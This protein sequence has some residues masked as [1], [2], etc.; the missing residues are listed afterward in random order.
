MNTLHALIFQLGLCGP[1]KLLLICIYI[2]LPLGCILN[3]PLHNTHDSL[4]HGALTNVDKDHNPQDEVALTAKRKPSGR[5]IVAE[6]AVGGSLSESKVVSCGKD[7]NTPDVQNE[8]SNDSG[9]RHSEEDPFQPGEPL[10]ITILWKYKY[11]ATYI[12]MITPPR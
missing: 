9:S 5:G 11:G 2:T 1:Y 10:R 12:T 4:T 7:Y 6:G 8:S 3:H